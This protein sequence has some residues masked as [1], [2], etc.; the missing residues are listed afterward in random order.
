MKF[1]IN[2]I[3]Y[4]RKTITCVNITGIK[5]G[6]CTSHD[7]FFIIDLVKAIKKKYSVNKIIILNPP[8]PYAPVYE[9]LYFFLNG[10][11]LDIQNKILHILNFK[12][13]TSFESFINLFKENNDYL[14]LSTNVF[15]TEEQVYSIYKLLYLFFDASNSPYCLVPADFK[16]I[17]K[18]HIKKFKKINL[19]LGFRL[20]GQ[21]FINNILYKKVDNIIVTVDYTTNIFNFNNANNI[22][23]SKLKAHLFKRYYSFSDF[24]YRL[25]DRFISLKATHTRRINTKRYLPINYKTTLTNQVNKEINQRFGTLKK[26]IYPNNIYNLYSYLNNNYTS[27][28]YTFINL[29][30]FNNISLTPSTLFYSLKK[31]SNKALT[32]NTK[33][34]Y[35]P[36]IS[37]QSIYIQSIDY[38]NNNNYIL[39][40]QCFSN[41]RGNINAI[42][43]EYKKDLPLI[44][45][46]N[47]STYKDVNKNFFLSI[48]NLK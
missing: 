20:M 45:A 2:N 7:V 46:P 48:L 38:C 32:K 1:E 6:C 37:G 31:L 10:L 39:I 4:S 18:S 15:I 16:V 34:S 9:T 24:R 40:N 17:Y 25:A 47:C 27:F 3:D 13:S 44:Q 12:K 5:K 41:S 36:Y 19:D 33:N 28:N 26:L 29:F 11:S 21:I 42:T 14:E 35:I 30:L 43:K 22:S 23:I 8:Y